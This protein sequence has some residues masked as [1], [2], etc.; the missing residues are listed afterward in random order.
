MNELRIAGMM[1]LTLLDYPGHMAATV[2]L[3]GCNMRCPFC[4]N[5]EILTKAP[6]IIPEAAVLDILEKRK[7][8]LEGVVITG[9]EPTLQPIEP[10]IRTVKEMGYSIK[11]DT[12]GLKPDVI[13]DL[14]NKNLVD[15]IA[16]DIKN[17][18]PRYAKT[19]GLSSVDTESIL[20]SVR[21]IMSCG[22]P[23]EFRT[24]IAPPLVDAMSAVGIGNMIRGAKL[25][26]LQPF[27][28]RDTVV[29]KTLSEPSDKLLLTFQNIM[30]HYVQSAVIR[31][32][33][34]GTN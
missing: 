11:L 10:F 1:K 21:I 20:S 34:I 17:D 16:M 14:L 6:E 27:V 5:S 18:L 33:D 19:A 7:N 31:G 26:V 30:K 3:E 28:P 32:R 15:Y 9:G 8:I 23:Y 13:E 25:H 12:N 4:H 2:F 29:C 22:V 24:T